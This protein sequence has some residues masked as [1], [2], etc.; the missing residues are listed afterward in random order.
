[1][2]S[3]SVE[4]HPTGWRRNTRDVEGLVY[5]TPERQR[6]AERPGLVMTLTASTPRLI[7]EPPRDSSRKQSGGRCR[8]KPRAGGGGSGGEG[9]EGGGA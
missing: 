6:A 3:L 5:Q 2:L 7:A 8:K 1:V 9:D 4:T